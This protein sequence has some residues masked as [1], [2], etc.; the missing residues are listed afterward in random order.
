MRRHSRKKN[1]TKVFIVVTIAAA[2]VFAASQYFLKKE[3]GTVVAT[4]NKQKIFKADLEKKL[5]NVFEGQNFGSQTAEIKIPEI[6]SLPKE[7]I[8]ILAKEIYIEKVLTKEA[9]NSKVVKSKEVAEKIAEIQEIILR[10]SYLDSIVKEEITDE[11]VSEKY[12]ELSN[13]LAGKK[14]YSIARIVSKTKEDSEKLAKELKSKKSVKFSDLAKKYSIDQESA[15]RGGDLGYVMEDNLIKEISD[16]IATLKKD[17]VSSPIQTKFGWYLI[18]VLDV[19]DAKALPFETVKDAIRE[20]IAQEKIN[21][22]NSKITKDVKIEVL[23]TLKD[24]KEKE[25]VE[26]KSDETKTE[27]KKSE[28]ISSEKQLAPEEE[29]TEIS[30]EKADEKTNS[31]EKTEEVVEEKSE[32]DKKVEKKSNE[33]QNSKKQNN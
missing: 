12:T 9:K 26:E 17:E 5:R 3:N 22:V 27:E 18:K 33:K 30:L 20:Q 29:K 16:T 4:V 28:E 32:T 2:L 7:V 1:S 10:Q 23:I 8:E 19:R 25:A 31:V 15:Q 21:E 13:Q 24:S 11:K 6:E 14:E